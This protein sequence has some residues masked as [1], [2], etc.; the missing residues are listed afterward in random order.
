ME[1]EWRGR[2]AGFRTHILVSLAA[3][4]L[5]HASLRQTEWFMPGLLEDWVRTDPVRMAHGILTGIGFL[6]AGVIFRTGFSV[7]GLTTAASLW[8]S[9]AIGTLAGAGMVALAGLATITTLI[10]LAVLRLVSRAA[11]AR[12]VVYVTVSWRRNGPGPRQAV[13]ALLRSRDSGL[14]PGKRDLCATSDQRRQS[15]R[16]SISDAD[17]DRLADELAA[18]PEVI[19]FTLD[20]REG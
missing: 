19:G 3:C 18:V 10:V 7:H 16:L 8:M 2:S 17:L 13:E 14:S 15:W 11:T 9:S 1:R 20:P 6:C 12:T 5:M 4:L